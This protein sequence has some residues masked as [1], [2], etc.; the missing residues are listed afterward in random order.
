MLESEREFVGDGSVTQNRT[1]E[2]RITAMVVDVQPN[3][4]LIIE[5]RRSVQVDDE[6]KRVVI[7]GVVRPG[8]VT[9]A[10]TVLS[11]NVAHATIRIEGDGP[12]HRATNRGLLGEIFDTIWHHVWPF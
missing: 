2:T 11:E 3:G 12:V 4:N 9:G 10:N 1:V 6:V 8:D 7:S 5:G